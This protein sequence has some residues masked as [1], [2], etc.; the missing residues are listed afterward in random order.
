MHMESSSSS[1]ANRE[2]IHSER[3]QPGRGGENPSDVDWLENSPDTIVQ[4]INVFLWSYV[5]LLGD[6]FIQSQLT[7][8]IVPIWEGS[9]HVEALP[10]KYMSVIPFSLFI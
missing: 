2:H 9:W 10:R 1:F 4:D 6:L 3:Q 7:L 8:Q 5:G